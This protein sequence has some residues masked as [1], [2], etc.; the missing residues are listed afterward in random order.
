M[1]FLAGRL[2]STEGAYFLQESKHAVGRLA[3]KTTKKKLPSDNNPSN[4]SSSSLVVD[5]EAQADVL[6]EVLRHYL[7][8]KLFEQPSN[9]SLFTASKWAIYIDPN[10]PS[11]V[12]ADALNPLR[13][14]L[15]LPQV[16][17]GPKRW[18]LPDSEHS[19]VASTAN[20]L[21]RDKYTRINTEKSKAA[22]EGLSQ[23]GKTFVF[24]T[25]F[26]Y[27]GAILT[28]GLTASNLEM[29]TSDDIKTKGKDI[30]QPKIEMIR[31][32][33]VPLQVWAKNMSK[34][35]HVQREEDIKEK[36]IIKELSKLLG[37]RKSSGLKHKF[38]FLV[39]YKMYHKLCLILWIKPNRGLKCVFFYLYK[40]YTKCIISC[41]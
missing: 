39:I 36:P 20:D 34:K 1:S 32:Q 21:R 18:K 8:S 23:I 6:P 5:N 28:F 41:V 38:S 17:F 37:A 35:W 22:A 10:K 11:P 3:E 2:A 4:D 27:G 13:A 9:S 15:S 7:P 29:H 16:T 24:A 19:V 26:V 14:Y 31:E 12:S 30:I 25:A 33:L 40:L